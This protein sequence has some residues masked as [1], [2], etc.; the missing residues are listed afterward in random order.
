M[1]RRR[2]LLED[3]VVKAMERAD[4]ADDL[5]DRLKAAEELLS[6]LRLGVS[7]TV[8]REDMILGFG[9][10]GSRWILFLEENKGRTPLLGKNLEVRVS[11]SS[12]LENLFEA[13]ILE[14]ESQAATMAEAAA[15][16]DRFLKSL[17]GVT[18]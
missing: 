11:A 3:L 15:S 5:N 10:V 4:Q 6:G 1:N 8:E 12:L 2:Q 17:S 13:L 14:A 9:K 16:V 18:A 7:A